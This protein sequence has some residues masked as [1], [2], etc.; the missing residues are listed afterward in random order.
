MRALL[1]EGS[2]FWM[3]NWRVGRAAGYG[4]GGKWFR[5]AGEKYGGGREMW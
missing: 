1:P 5:G 4:V 3:I 2:L